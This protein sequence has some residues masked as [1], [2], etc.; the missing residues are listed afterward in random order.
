MTLFARALLAAF[1]MTAPVLAQND[2]DRARELLSQ[3]PVFDGHNDLPFAI[4]LANEHRVSDFPYERLD[5]RFADV[6]TDAERLEAGGLGAQFWS[7]Y[8]PASL[9]EPE[10]V[11]TVLEQIDI[12]DRLIAQ[13]PDLLEKAKTAADVRR[14]MA[15]GKVASMYGV[16]G[17][18]AIANSLAVLRKLYDLGARYMTLT[19][20]ASLDWADSSTDQPKSD[21]LSPFGEE[22]VREM[23]RL[24]MLVDLSHVSEATMNDALDV[25]EAPVIFSHSSARGVSGHPRNVPDSVLQR[26]PD[27]GGVVMITFVEPFLNEGRRQWSA[28]QAAEEARLKSLNPGWTD[29]Q[30]DAAMPESEMPKASLSDAADHI[31]YVRDLIGVDHIGIGG[32][33]DGISTYPEGLEDVSTYPALF[34]ELLRRGYS[35]EDLAKISSGNI[36]RALEA[37]ETVSTRLKRERAPS[38]LLFVEDETGEAGQ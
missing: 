10:A 7:V 35:E 18:H 21:G 24:G 26:L 9:P 36:L 11:V 12:A 8:V 27:N 15:Q 33:F 37:A 6:V 25:A 19:H 31:D 5:D 22:V 16:E 29:E 13:H 34:A 23:N 28:R 32:D 1:L 30:V 2:T 17:G 20:S 3:A 4:R 14:I 38:E